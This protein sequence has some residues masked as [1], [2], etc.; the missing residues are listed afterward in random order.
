[1]E[2]RS[3]RS[4]TRTRGFWIV[5]LLQTFQRQFTVLLLFYLYMSVFLKDF[6]YY[7]SP[8]GGQDL[9]FSPLSPPPLLLCRV[10]HTME[11]LNSMCKL[12]TSPTQTSPFSA[13]LHIQLPRSTAPL[14]GVTDTP[15][16]PN[17][18]QSF[19]FPLPKLVSLPE[20]YFVGHGSIGQTIL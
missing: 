15:S 13:D 12:M 20:F 16:V 11:A 14:Q 17:R 1:M 10:P 6:S 3:G 19:S 9:G 5:A 7:S 4:Q 18:K 8:Q 2:I